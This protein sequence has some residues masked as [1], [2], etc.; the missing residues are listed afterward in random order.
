MSHEHGV[1]ALI[2]SGSGVQSDE[3][4]PGCIPGRK[5]KKGRKGGG[6]DK[7]TWHSIA[8]V[9]EIFVV[10][11]LVSGAAGGTTDLGIACRNCS[12]SLGFAGF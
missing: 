10:C 2:R 7:R 11:T 12:Q 3:F 4:A 6:Q 9:R 5:G 1:L 8:P